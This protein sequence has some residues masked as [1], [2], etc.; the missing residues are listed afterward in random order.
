MI[1]KRARP[2]RWG[3]H[4]RSRGRNSTAPPHSPKNDPGADRDGTATSA[5]SRA[6]KSG[7]GEALRFRLESEGL[8]ELFPETEAADVP[9][10]GLAHLQARLRSSANL[11]RTAC[12]GLLLF[13]KLPDRFEEMKAADL[14]SRY[15]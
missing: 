1:A 15:R 11:A 10:L 5:S 4:H 13:M 7:S 3:P 6:L 12:P 2:P 8:H 9:I 14:L